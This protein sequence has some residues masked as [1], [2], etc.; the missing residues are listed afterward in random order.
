MPNWCSNELTITGPEKDLKKFKEFAQGKPYFDSISSKEI[1]ECLD[2]NKFIPYPKK[3]KKQDELVYAV[4]EKEDALRELAGYKTMDDYQQRFFDSKNPRKDWN[5]K[6]GFNSG[7]YDWTCQHWG[8]KWGFCEPQLMYQEKD[9]L[10]Y[11]F[12]SAW[13]PMCPVIAK[14]A[15][16][17][18][19]LSF[20][21]KYIE[22]SMCF[23]GLMH[24]NEGE[25]KVDESYD[26]GSEAYKS[27]YEE[28]YGSDEED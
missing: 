15:K 9:E 20:E 13:S 24:C 12:N 25:V 5:M 2:A 10:F 21:Y 23:A 11:T 1:I 28:N 8:S 14:M 22:P 27:I 18:P 19:M 4:N 6:D 17:F 3:Y 16:M 26:S 7:G